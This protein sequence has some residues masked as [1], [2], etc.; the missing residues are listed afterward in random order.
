MDL[1]QSFLQLRPHSD[2]LQKIGGGMIIAAA[3]AILLGWDV[4]IQL[5]L[6]PFFPT[7][8]L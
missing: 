4:T 5:W 1:G 7:F 3:I 6:A 2:L 8:P